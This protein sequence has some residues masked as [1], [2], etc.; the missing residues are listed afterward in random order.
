MDAVQ[1]V[2]DLM[3][4]ALDER[5]P[6]GERSNAAFSALRIIQEFNLLGNKTKNVAADI[7]EK[8]VAFTSP[9]V[10]DEIA[11]RADKF[12]SGVDRVIGSTAQV[13]GRIK[14]ITDQLRPPV[15]PEPPTPARR[16]RAER[17]GRS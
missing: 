3:N 4:L 14:Q 12:A 13:V 6:D 11:S 5:T 9:A 8:L 1:K 17:R 2:K 10:V 7:L 16:R 15:P